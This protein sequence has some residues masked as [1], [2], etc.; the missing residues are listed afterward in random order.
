MIVINTNPLLLFYP[1]FPFLDIFLICRGEIYI[2]RIH[3]RKSLKVKI[4][5]ENKSINV[6]KIK[7]NQLRKL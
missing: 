4:E 7:G 2:L 5:N 3:Q 6:L 1:S